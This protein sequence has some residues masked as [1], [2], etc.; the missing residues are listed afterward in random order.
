MTEFHIHLLV[1]FAV[2]AFLFLSA[3]IVGCFEKKTIRDFAL[4]ES[5][6][7]STYFEN[8]INSAVANGFTFVADGVHP[9]YQSLFAALFC[10][11]DQK[12]LTVIADGTIINLRSRKTYLISQKSDGTVLITIT[13]PGTCEFD[14]LTQRE[15]MLKASFDELW[16]KHVSRVDESGRM[17]TF[18]P[19]GAWAALDEIWRARVSRIVNRG[20]ANYL[21]DGRDFYRYTV[22]GSFRATIVHGLGQVLRPSNWVR[23]RRRLPG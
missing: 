21:G 1:A 5:R 13:D 7:G 19:A 12:T 6:P 8:M 11:P 17:V 2:P 23:H 22:W 16:K 20:L 4:V 18:K 14:P 3:F 10:S 9:K 15:I